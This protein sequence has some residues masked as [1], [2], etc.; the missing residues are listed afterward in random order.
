MR[1]NNGAG[2]GGEIAVDY[3]LKIINGTVYDGEGN[4]PLAT[5]V[6]VRNGLIVEVGDCAGSAAQ[7]ID[8]A[9]HIVTPGFIDLHTHYD[10]QVSWDADM[11]PSV[12]HGV[13][14]VVMG[15]CGV[16]FAPV[17]PAD[18]DKLVRLMEGVEDIPGTALAEGISWEWETLLA[19]AVRRL[20][21][22]I[23]DYCGMRD[24]GRIKEG[25]KANINVIDY[26][27]LR[28]FAPRMVQDLPAGGRRLLQD[29]AGYRAVLVDG[30][31][32][33]ENDTLT[34]RY[35]GRLVRMGALS[36]RAAA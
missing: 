13:S 1:F 12:N 34:G 15:S 4:A 3:D 11:Q 23:A 20:T 29:A 22:D 6:A 30:E 19:D 8:A 9:G 14:T 21:S 33:V 16:G 7:V 5:N 28:L 27:G 31:P 10:G 35:P 36:Q 24:R 2:S 25:L 18:R 26:D 17:G 32:L